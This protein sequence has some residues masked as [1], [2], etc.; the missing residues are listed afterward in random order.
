VR[1]RALLA[2]GWVLL[3]AAGG[4]GADP[5]RLNDIQVVGSHNSY[6][7]AMPSA[8]F[9]TLRQAR[10]EIAD[11]LEYSHLPLP[12]QLTL[13]V[14]ALE[15][16]VFYDPDGALFPGRAAP[17][18]RF[19]VLHVQ[20][21][22]DRSS[23]PS[24]VACLLVLTDWSDEHPDHLPIFISFNAKDSPIEWP[25]AVTPLPF[26]EDAWQAFDAELIAVLG[27]RLIRPA[28]VF[29]SGRLEWPLLASARGRF[30]AVLDEGGDKR[31]TYASRWRERAMFATLEA[32]EPG[33]AVLIVNDP[34][35]DFARIQQLVARGFIV[36]TRADADTLEAR[37]DDTTRRERAFA[38]GAQVVSTDYYLPASHFGTDYVVT[39]PAPARCNPVRRPDGCDLTGSD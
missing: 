3:L 2:G 36:R 16:D 6:K 29:E 23:C 32:G 38:S 18:S 35:A 34:V 5:L 33:S 30:M 31:R 15:L 25:G 19:P 20:N 21:L 26:D 9:E 10:P 37:R 7:L 14:R 13:G 39:L 11:T 12:D 8:N 28:E 24:L 17:E 1:I 27:D 22:D 4:A